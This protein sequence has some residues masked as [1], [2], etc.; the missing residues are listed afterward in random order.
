MK[1]K[2][3]KI[4][5]LGYSGSGKST[6]AARLGELYGANV[7]HLDT[8]H[9]LP[10]WEERGLEEKRKIISNFLK[11]NASWVIDGNYS[12]QF[13]DERTE[14][15]DM[16]VIL[17]FGRFSCLWR[18]IKRYRKY[19]GRTRPD[20]S[21]GC[22]EK[23]DGEFIWWVLHDGRTKSKKAMFLALCKKL[24]DKTVIL[25]NQRQLDEFIRRLEK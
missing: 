24:P 3:M 11:A 10:N 21:E 14:Q 15:A 12:K 20:M 4:A 18:V 6:L 25:K 7:L 8:V 17:L 16:I 1:M 2:A 9:F 5:V 19:K 23:L 13:F 22:D